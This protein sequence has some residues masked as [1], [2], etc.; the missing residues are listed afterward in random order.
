MIWNTTTVY[1]LFAMITCRNL[2]IVDGIMS[3]LDSYTND[4]EQLIEERTRE[5]EEERLKSELLLYSM[6]P[7]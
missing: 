7:R 5:L 2:S 6:M 3:K 4:L 1:C